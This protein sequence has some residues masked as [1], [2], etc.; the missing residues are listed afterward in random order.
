MTL[1]KLLL[2]CTQLVRAR[3]LDVEIFRCRGPGIVGMN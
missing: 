3:M 1:Q 2:N